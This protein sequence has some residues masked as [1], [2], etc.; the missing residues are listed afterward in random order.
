MDIL[1][2]QIAFPSQQQT[3]PDGLL[4]IG[5]DLS[6]E[7]LLLAYRSGIFPWFSYE[8]I[9]H[10]FC[11]PQRMVLF[12]ASIKISKSMKQVLNSGI[13]NFTQD[14]DF[15]GVI[16]NCSYTHSLNDGGT[17][18]DDD[19]IQAYMKMHQIGHAH[20]IEV[21]QDD[22]LV[23]G[24]YGMVIGK[25]FCGESMFSKVSNASKAALIHICRSNNFSLIDCQVSNDHL[26]SMGAE[27]ISRKR[28]LEILAL[29]GTK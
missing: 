24:L 25:I 19:F 13:F 4:A 11:P 7:R 20:S 27:V 17:W 28:F 9:I 26:I 6:E 8:G 29:E 2:K 23:G 22:I 3:E 1:G 12:P 5:G 21:W 14:K 10:W 18:I 16:K 15:E